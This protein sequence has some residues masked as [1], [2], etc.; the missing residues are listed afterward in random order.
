MRNTYL[1]ALCALVAAALVACGG[2]GGGGAADS[3][4]ATG[5]PTVALVAGTAQFGADAVVKGT[6]TDTGAPVARNST[7][8]GAIAALDDGSAI[9][10][11]GLSRSPAEGARVFKVTPQ[12][13]VTPLQGTWNTRNVV[14]GIF[15]C[16]FNDAIALG[17]GSAGKGL[18][19]QAM[20]GS[21]FIFGGGG[22][23]RTLSVPQMTAGPLSAD[24]AGN[25][26][27]WARDGAL[28]R[29]ETDG[30]L[31]FLGNR[32]DVVDQSLGTGFAF[33]QA[34]DSV[35]NVYVSQFTS[36]VIRK[37][38]PAGA[39]STVTELRGTALQTDDAGN[40]YS[41][42]GP[43][44]LKRSPSGTVEGFLGPVVFSANS[45]SDALPGLIVPPTGFAVGPSGMWISGAP[46][47]S[48]A[49]QPVRAAGLA[50]PALPTGAG[51]LSVLAGLGQFG[52]QPDT[53]KMAGTGIPARFTMVANVAALADGSVMAVANMSTAAGRLFRIAADGRVTPLAGGW[54]QRALCGTA[55]C[56]FPDQLAL[57]TA[58]SGK[59]YLFQA[60][61]ATVSIFGNQGL[62]SEFALPQAAGTSPLAVD[63]AGAVYFM[64]SGPALR[65]RAAD[66]TVTLVAGSTAGSADGTGAAAQFRSVSG[67]AVDAQGN[68]YVADNATIRKVT[69]GGAVT[70][71]AGSPGAIGSADGTGA[72]A[73]F[74]L[75]AGIAVDAAG[76]VYVADPLNGAIRKVSAAGVVTTLSARPDALFNPSGLALNGQA[77][78]IG[79]WQRI[80]RLALP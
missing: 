37:V 65:K 27:F 20:D 48:L 40:L 15:G 10:L 32:Q 18:L 61:T 74:S 38:T 44:I 58:P 72:A 39:V 17:Q 77:L 76:N 14:C 21:L 41:I 50:S 64:D 22:V 80:S 8:F 31:Y 4:P 51:P 67:L 28:R 29:L 34:V 62:E 26:Y 36:G 24:R 7:S 42:N 2:G 47:V 70:T 43:N 49:T 55:G 68:V 1:P 73:R 11:G 16:P 59:A 30:G 63:S 9:Y 54:D 12:G 19:Y 53:G 6:L 45:N 35:G 66:G 60:R 71:L 13:L 75:L 52:S 33:G 78:M 25:I 57:A 5:A 69:P 56:I 23:E 46:A 3:S 79:E